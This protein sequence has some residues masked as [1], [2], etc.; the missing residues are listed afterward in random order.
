[1]DIPNCRVIIQASGG[2]SE[3][4]LLQEALRGSR[5][6]SETQQRTLGAPPKTHLVLIDFLDLHDPSLEGMS[7]K[8]M[9]IYRK[10]G[11][12]IHEVESP[13]Q[14]DWKKYSPTNRGEE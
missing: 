7:R 11:W 14:I 8:R 6:L 12:A 2:S 9:E 5:T 10:Q 3:V 1:V 13:A 4:E